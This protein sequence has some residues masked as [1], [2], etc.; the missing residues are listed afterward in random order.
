[1]EPSMRPVLPARTFLLFRSCCVADESPEKGS[2]IPASLLGT[3]ASSLAKNQDFPVATQ[4][5]AA[6]VKR[7]VRHVD[8]I[9][10][11][12]VEEYLGGGMSCVYRAKDPILGKTLAIKVLREEA[13]ADHAQRE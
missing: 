7:S 1:M 13:N 11:Y 3:D 4:R 2:S 5:T 9:G 10:K 8:H 12:L 6:V